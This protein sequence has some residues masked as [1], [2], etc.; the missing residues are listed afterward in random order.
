LDPETIPI[1]EAAPP[2]AFEAPRTP[3]NEVVPEVV[4]EVVAG[5]KEEEAALDVGTS[6]QLMKPFLPFA[7]VLIFIPPLPSSCEEN[8]AVENEAV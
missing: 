4:L 2:A 6:A 1:L 8:A 7:L 3:D 5:T